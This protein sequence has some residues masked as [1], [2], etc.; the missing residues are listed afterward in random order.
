MSV[1]VGKWTK[2]K[3]ILEDEN[4][5]SH[6]P[7][8]KLFKEESLWELMDLYSELMI[9]PSFGHKGKGV[10][11]ITSFGEDKFGVQ[12][13]L[14][15]ITIH[16]KKPLFKYLRENH[17][18][19]K[20]QYI[21]QK[22]ISLAK[23]EDSPIDIRVIVQRKR[24]SSEWIVTGK[25]AKIARDGFIITSAAKELVPVEEAIERSSLNSQL[26][27]KILIELDQV[28]LN[29]ARQLEK[30]Y[31]KSRLIG[32]DMGIDQEGKIWIIEANL[33]PNIAMFNKVEDKSDYET[34]KSYRKG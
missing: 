23:I 3:L 19:P 14:N 20:R 30:Y 2:Y 4:L 7:V 22:W 12:A 24:K 17:C 9:K 33:T 6:L 26:I 21:I 18:S 5:A 11:Q 16:G 8:T 32:L 25:L 31:T 1:S 27:Q 29:T 34:I 28:S 13:G 15:K 10:I